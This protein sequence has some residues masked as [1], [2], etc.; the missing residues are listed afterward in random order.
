MAITHTP[1]FKFLSIVCLV[2][3]FSLFLSNFSNSSKAQTLNYHKLKLSPQHEYLLKCGYRKKEINLKL[4]VEKIPSQTAELEVN[5]IERDMDVRC[6]NYKPDIGLTA[7]IPS[8]STGITLATNPT[9]FFYIPDVNL[10]GIEGEFILRDE[11]EEQVYNKIVPLKQ[12]DSIIGIELSDSPSLPSLKAGKSYYWVFSLL[13][14]KVDRSTNA[15][16][17]GWIKRIEPNSALKQKLDT[18]SSQQQPVIYATNGIWY[19]ALASLAK[20]RCTSPNN[21]TIASDWESLLQQVGLPEISKK[22]LA[23]CN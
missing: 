22:P 12:G 21:A 6:A 9:F 3:S 17:A 5:R 23:L 20:L 1:L 18:A 8:S 2:S 19:E 13:L 16:V 11:Q 10:E 14:D 4:P 7:L 15:S